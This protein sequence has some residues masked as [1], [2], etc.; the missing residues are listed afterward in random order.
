[1]A[2]QREQA[3]PQV[4]G[5]DEGEDQIREIELDVRP[6]V[7]DLG[8]LSVP[9]DQQLA[10]GALLEALGELLAGGGLAAVDEDDLVPAL[11]PRLRPLDADDLEAAAHRHRLEAE[12]LERLD[13]AMD[14]QAPEAHGQEGERK[15]DRQSEEAGRI[16]KATKKIGKSPQSKGPRS[17]FYATGTAF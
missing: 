2:H 13:L 16:H 14:A 5:A 11:Q 17:T 6:V 12:R 3:D 7:M 4:E 15:A 10:L 8:E 1:M 9:R